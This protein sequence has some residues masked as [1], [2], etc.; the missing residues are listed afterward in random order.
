MP[1]GFLI[2]GGLCNQSNQGLVLSTGI[3]TLLTASATANT[4]GPF[5]QLTAAAP[6]DVVAMQVIITMASDP[7]GW[8][9]FLLDIAIGA[10]GSEIV[11][12][13]NICFDSQ[14]Y[15]AV[16]KSVLIPLQIPAGTRI[17]ARCQSS[18]ASDTTNVAV[19]LFDGAF[20]ASEG[21]AG[22]D[23][24][25]TSLS[26][27]TG[28]SGSGST[29]FAQLVAATVR[30]Y[31]G[32]LICIASGGFNS[33]NNNA[34]QIGIGSSGN[35]KPLVISASAGASTGFC[36]FPIEVL[37]GSRLSF[38]ANDPVSVLGAYK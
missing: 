22:Y 26:T 25:G 28:T 5:T 12:V 14:S 16:V 20:E 10:S 2:G 9:N 30:D 7:N 31:I 8:S 29:T 11:V 17:S 37:A 34:F 3:G 35:E 23:D 27:S 15:S 24:L 6:S 33:N 13:P 19:T 36:Y 32:F 1:G 4:K 18:T 38:A 21:V